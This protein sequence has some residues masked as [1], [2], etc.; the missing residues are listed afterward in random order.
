MTRIATTLLALACSATAAIASDDEHPFPFVVSWDEGAPSVVDSSP[1]FP[2][3]L[4]TAPLRVKDGHLADSDGRRVR[5]LGVN[6]AGGANFPDPAESPAIAKR[7]RHLGVTCVRLHHMDSA[8]AKPNLFGMDGGV[9]EHPAPDSLAR[10]DALIAALAEQGIRVD[11]NLHVG[12]IYGPELGLPKAPAGTGAATHGKAVGYFEERA[13][14]LQKQFARDLLDRVNPLRGKRLAEDPVL[15]MVELVNEDSLLGDAGMLAELPDPWQSQISKRWNAWLAQHDPTT[16]AL[17]AHW[18]DGIKPAGPDLLGDGRFATMGGWVVEHHAPAVVESALEDPAGA[19]DRPAGRM[20]RISPRKLDGTSWHLQVH[21][22]GFALVPGETYTL[23]FA[24]R[25]AAP[26]KLSLSARQDH[27]Q[28]AVAGLTA[29]ARLDPAWRRFSYTFTASPEAGPGCRLT[30]AAG[31]DA[32]EYFLADVTLHSG[33]GGIELAADQRIEDR[34][35]PLVEVGASAPG[36]DFAAFLIA[37]ED[38]FCQD[39]RRFVHEDL[40]CAA[41]VLASQASYGGVGGLR[42]ESRLDMVDMHAYWQHPSFPHRGWDMNDFRVE[43]TPMSAVADGGALMRVAQYRAAGMPFTV[44]EYD[45]PAP[46]EYAAESVPLAFAV[47]ARQDWD[48][49]FMFDYMSTSAQSMKEPRIATFFNCSQHP[50]KLA[51][52]P[53]AAEMFIA[54]AVPAADGLAHLDF[55][56]DR[57]EAAAAERLGNGFWRLA[58]SGGDKID[59]LNQ[60]IEVAF[61][62]VPEARVESRPAA[63]APAMT[64]SGGERGRVVVQAPRVAGAFGRIRGETVEAG[65]LRISAEANPRSYAAVAV[66]SR[67]GKPLG[68]SRRMLLAAV[69]KAENSGLAW[70]DDRHSAAKAWTGEV[71]VTGVSA[72]IELA[73]AATGLAVWALDGRGARIAEV[74]SASAEGRLRFRI[75]PEQRT[76]WYEIAPR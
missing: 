70:S 68:E 17:R 71:R 55:P 59:L 72:A 33:G 43:N 18:N 29:A 8:W 41:P 5:L 48:G 75:S 13:I 3:S 76:V 23:A 58:G 67:D 44:T 26:R 1:L 42:R 19:T 52:L 14:A 10:L 31:D 69:D 47:A 7:L 40:K 39:M 46:S 32:T 12:R 73:T 9:A 62:A 30:F 74:P 21:R 15:A 25:A 54:G 49:V 51:F 50:A 45:H 4:G 2:A 53:I 64:W 16:D 66:A 28:Y 56:A 11:L 37:T 57:V 63:A 65:A 61:A 22:P 35:I 36:R 27:G 20:L 60:R 34:T 38:A 24:A 6:F